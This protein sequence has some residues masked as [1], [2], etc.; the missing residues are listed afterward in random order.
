MKKQFWKRGLAVLLGLALS[1]QTSTGSLIPSMTSFAYTERSATI[2]AS[3]LNVRSGAGTGYSSVAKLASGT[4]ITVTNEVKGSDNRTWYQIRFT[5]TGGASMTGYVLGTYVRFPVS[6]ST[7][8]SFEAQLSAQG[9][10]ES[11]KD[12]LRQLH[13]QFPN[14]VFEAQ[15]TGLDWNTVVENEMV[16]P[17]S[18]VSKDSISSYKSLQDGAYNWDTSSWVGFDGD[19]WVAASQELLSYYMDP[20][21]QLDQVSIFQF[22]SHTYDSS[23]QTKEGLQEMIKGTFLENAVIT[24]GSGSTGTSSTSTGSGSSGTISSGT[25]SGGPGV[26]SSSK[27]NTITAGSG[28]ITAGSSSTS[29]GSTSGSSGSS[30]GGSVTVELRSPSA[31]ISK[32]DAPLLTE[33]VI[34]GAKP[35]D[36]VSGSGSSTVISPGNSS[37]SVTTTTTQS[38]KTYA[39]MIM[40]AAQTSGVN[41]Y[42]LA[43]MIL[44]EQGKKGTGRSISGTVSGYSGYYNYFNVGAYASDGLSA[45]ERGLWYA[46]QSGS[47]GRPWNTPEKSISGGAQ[48]YGEN[49]VQ[50]GQDTFYLKKFNVQGSN[51]YKHQYMTNVDGAASEASL[52]AEGYTDHLKNTALRFKIPVYNNMPET[53]CAKPTGDGSPNNKLKSLN[54][55]GFTMTPSFS[56]DTTEYQVIVDQ[57]VTNVNV[58]ASVIDSKAGISGTGNVQ[59]LNASNDITVRVTAQNGSI[60]DYKIRV[61]KQNNGPT[62]NGMVS[63]GGTGSGISVG[64]GTTSSDGSSPVITVGPGGSS[65][66]T[67]SGTSSGISTGSSAPTPGGSSVTI[68]N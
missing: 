34:I 15:K 33:T 14:W 17:R 41:P 8:S 39:D 28:S 63:S 26:S 7:D 58:N 67:S 32:K 60:R 47:Y 51:I 43:A 64:S 6:Y 10:P 4:L 19:T 16:L 31:S 29:S 20:R 68:I 57:S 53:A 1:V 62:Y 54:V 35:G 12:G 23:L 40:E 55:D 38:S 27:S 18:L 50:A 2:N 21:N 36:D 65:G 37:S 45:V 46:S 11:Y 13:A 25:V 5:G 59:V 56:R 52:F 42:V 61:V 48:F 24:N 22:L 44:Q 66:S 9:F 49:Y 3:S 30:S